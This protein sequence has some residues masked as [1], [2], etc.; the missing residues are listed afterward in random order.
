MD[1]D[2]VG[3]F[4]LFLSSGAIG[5][6]VIAL[7]AYEAKLASKLERMRL[8]GADDSAAESLERIGELEERVQ[9]LTDRAE[10][11]DKLLK[12]LGWWD[13]LTAEEK[14]AAEGK[15]WKTDLSG[16]IQRVC[17]KHGCSGPV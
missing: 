10:F 6:G 3:T 2:G 9:Q 13:D 4:A 15:N 16:G 12:Q 17:I 8:E 14:Q 5:L 7:K 1:W 11:T